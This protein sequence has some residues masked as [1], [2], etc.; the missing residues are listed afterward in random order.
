LDDLLRPYPQ[1]SDSCQSLDQVPRRQVRLCV[2]VSRPRLPVVVLVVV[3][4]AVPPAGLGSLVRAWCSSVP[5]Q[6]TEGLRVVII[7][8]VRP[9]GFGLSRMDALLSKSESAGV[10]AVGAMGQARLTGDDLRGARPLELR[11]QEEAVMTLVSAMPFRCFSP[12]RLLDAADKCLVWEALRPD[13]KADWHRRS[14]REPSMLC[15]QPSTA[16]RCLVQGTQPRPWV[17]A[18]VA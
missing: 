4:H 8:T 14:Q 7:H 5:R 10:Q 16:V 13:T 17:N 11:A 18:L 12:S 9:R 3:V 2:L 15:M 6:D 1:T